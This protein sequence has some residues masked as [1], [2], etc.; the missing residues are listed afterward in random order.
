V[1]AIP[2]APTS[3]ASDSDEDLLFYMSLQTEDSSTAEE[4]WEEFFLRH[5]SYLVG[6][7][8]RFQPTLGD[9][10]V[11]D[12]AKDTLIRVF[13][14]AHT[15]TPLK[16]GDPNR[17]RARIRAWLGQIANRLFLSTMRRKPAIDFV[18]E[19]FLGAAEPT[20]EDSHG[21][22]P[23]DS[24][25]RLLLRKALRTLTD[26]ERDILLASYAWYEPGPG[27]QRMPSDKLAA[28]TARFQTT[29]VN[30]RQIR[31]RAFDKVEQYIADHTNE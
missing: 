29:A 28:L 1:S 9:L 8:R 11:E 23:G 22:R 5:W 25:R 15:F 16:N 24:S 6:V 7:C 30:I 18:D 14:K 13:Q 21:Q 19:P 2:P 26:R 27:C 4:A 12:L 31:A 3:F 20:T 17:A 10:G